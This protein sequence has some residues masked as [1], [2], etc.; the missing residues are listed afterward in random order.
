MH[1]IGGRHALTAN[2][3]LIVAGLRSAAA[4]FHHFVLRDATL[5]G[6]LPWQDR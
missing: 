3:V 6:M 5:C 2:A 4:P 1:Q